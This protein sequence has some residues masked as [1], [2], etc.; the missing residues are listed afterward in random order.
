MYNFEIEYIKNI[1][2]VLLIISFCRIFEAL[3]VEWRNST[4]HFTPLSE[5]GNEN[6]KYLIPLSGNRTHNR[7]AYS[8]TL[9]SPR[10]DG[11]KS[12]YILYKHSKNNNIIIQNLKEIYIYFFPWPRTCHPIVLRPDS[13]PPYICI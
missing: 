4:L 12:N 2:V 11:L 1:I 9:M 5:R 6:N 10:Y 7:K 8:G 3:C 13:I